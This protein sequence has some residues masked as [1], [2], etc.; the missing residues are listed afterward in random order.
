MIYG[1]ETSE[2]D[3]ST[4]MSFSMICPHSLSKKYNPQ[5]TIE[6]CFISCC[7]LLFNRKLNGA[8]YQWNVTLSKSHLRDTK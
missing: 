7:I 5:R 6:A 2:V 4:K 1:K 3:I 8:I